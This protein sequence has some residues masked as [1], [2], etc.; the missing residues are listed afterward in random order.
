MTTDYI[1]QKPSFTALPNWLRGKA[2]PLELA[3]LWCLQSHYPNIHPSLSLLAAEAGIARSTLCTVLQGLERKGWLVREQ[4]C[5]ASGRRAN[6]RYCL[7]IW[8]A[9]WPLE[10]GSPPAGLVR[11]PDYQKAAGIVRET[12]GD[13]PGDGLEV[14]QEKK[15]NPTALEPPLPPAPQ[16]GL[17]QLAVAAHPCRDGGQVG[18]APEPQPGRD[19]DGF[20][21]HPGQLPAA[22]A[23]PAAE[24]RPVARPPA[25]E[26]ELLQATQPQPQQP[27]APRP[28]PEPPDPEAIAPV[29]PKAK[30]REAGFT[31]T[32]EDVPA[33]LLPVVRELLAF[34]ACKG[35][36]RTERAWSAQ[37]G[38]L[39]RIQDDARGG[40]EAVRAQLEAGSQAAVF[41][42]PWMAVTFANWERY[43]RPATPIVGTGF[44]GKRTT[45]DRVMGAIALV[46]E[47]ER[48]AAAQPA[49]ISEL[50]LAGVA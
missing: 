32:A 22:A 44:S 31:P 25:I 28:L 18:A 12:D 38:Q 35:G 1:G 42:K 23:A 20:L 45:M 41:G 48:R 29:K 10:A 49:G 9:R 43:G 4:G 5:M 15:I 14:D 19:R 27:N 26:P 2:T 17:R 30:K 40:T 46:E 7:T 37:L 13:S 11:E 47:R 36:K 16:G 39:E 50:L 21:V 6:T 34:W 33:A 8:D 24:P 3:V